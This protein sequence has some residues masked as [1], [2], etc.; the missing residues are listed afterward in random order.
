MM[1][2]DYEHYLALVQEIE[3]HNKLYFGE[4]NP[5]ISDY[6][7]DQ[8]VK[9][10]EVLE[11]E[12]PQWA[13]ASPTQ[14]VG[15]STSKGF[16]SIKHIY[17]M[18]SLSNTYSKEQITEFI[19]RVHKDLETTNVVFCAEYKIDGVALSLVYEKGKLIRAVT[20]G[21]GRMGDEVT[22][23]IKTIASIPQQVSGPVPDLFEVRGEVYLPIKR[24]EAL[25]KA[26]EAEGKALFANPR[27]AAAGSLK[28]KDH[29]EV[30]KRGLEIIC[31]AL[32]GTDLPTQGAVHTQIAKWGFPTGGK[33]GFSVC[34]DSEAL[35]AYIDEVEQERSRLPFE[36]D[37]V[38]L[39]V[40]ELK[41]H[42]QLGSSAKSPKW[43]VA[44]K[45]AALQAESK[46]LDIT[47]QIGRTGRATPVA[48][49]K[50]TPLAGSVI[51]RS[52]LHNIEE[53]ERKDIRIGDTVVIEKGGDV[54]PKVSHVIVEK[55][56]GKEE[57][58]VM[59][60]HCPV[61]DAPLEKKEGEVAVFCTNH[62]SCGAT[63]ERRLSFFV[64]KGAMNIDSL[65]SE[66]IRK[67]I[68]EGLVSSPS[69]LYRLK[70]ED[71][72][73]LEGFAEKSIHNLLHNLEGSK[74]RSLARFVFALSIP[75][76]GKVAAEAI[77]DHIARVED[78]FEVEALHLET[79]H[80]IG[81]KVISEI[82][83]YFSDSDHVHEV[84]ALLHL[85]ITPT[86][87]KREVIEHP[88][89]GKVFVLTG[90]LEHYTRAQAGEEIKKRGGKV[91][92]SVSK[93]TDFCAL[94]KRSGLKACKS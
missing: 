79:V 83:T 25:N 9:R 10:V 85:G 63:G 75:G 40:N 90:T 61:C 45:Y 73:G 17:P 53:I 24:F 41:F 54:I 29:S 11:R 27:N 21:D 48:I 81:D 55:R 50:P 38:V 94:W 80:G 52:T 34:S 49:L 37:G 87:E 64:S 5:E 6:E 2:I 78:L 56:T 70:K 91:T 86:K 46:V 26:R 69:D 47:V 62:K 89:Q 12:H 28:L 15:E 8:L 23:N 22:E 77:A 39:K 84:E 93:N 66:I 68:S 36:I 32:L 59:P 58:F 42:D 65:G 4:F 16:K 13:T 51:S 19:E 18:L 30:K 7:Y 44:Y 57:P 74:T 3:K 14:K 1:T 92:S 43:A 88:F 20:R 71:L 67:L 35:F 33:N 72:E 82:Q 76:V 31:Y 60:S